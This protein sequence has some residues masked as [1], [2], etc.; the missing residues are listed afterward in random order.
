MDLAIVVA[1]WRRRNA[2]SASETDMIADTPVLVSPVSYSDPKLT[3]WTTVALAAIGTALVVAT[4]S[5]WWCGL[6]AGV[7]VF[8]AARVAVMR[9]VLAIGSPLVLAFSRIA[10]EPQL[11]WLALALLGADLVALVLRARQRR[12]P[13][14]PVESASPT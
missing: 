11:A 5:R 8:L 1:T 2:F 7:G 6:A 12:N 4:F 13:P 9:Y 3:S 10:H 14:T